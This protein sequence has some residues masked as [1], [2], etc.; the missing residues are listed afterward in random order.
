MIQSD[1]EIIKSQF[2]QHLTCC[3]ANLCFNQHGARAK[4]VNIAL[5]E[6]PE[7][8]ARGAVCAPDRLNLIAFEKLWK[9]VAMLSYNA[10]KRNSQIVTKCKV[11]FARTFMNASFED[12]VDELIS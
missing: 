5:V 2:R 3:R 7:S 11:C 9:L 10:S 1:L 12:L 8:A 6:F 4:N